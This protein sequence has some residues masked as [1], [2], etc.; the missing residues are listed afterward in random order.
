MTKVWGCIFARNATAGLNMGT[1][2]GSGTC[3][4]VN[5]TFDANGTSGCLISDNS[6]AALQRALILNNIFSNNSAY[7]LSINGG[8]SVADARLIANGVV[9]AGNNFFN[10]TS[11]KYN[12]TTLGISENETTVDPQYT[13][14]AGGDFS[15]G[16]NLKATGFPQTFVSGFSATRSYMDPGAAQRQEPAGGG[17]GLLVHPGMAGGARG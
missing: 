9:I 14:A 1:T 8:T 2:A 16:A 3:V 4:I 6:G 15:I 7:G 13:N 10:N 5:N 17:G 12:P 11:G